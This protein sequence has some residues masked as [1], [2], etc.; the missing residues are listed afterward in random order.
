ME[1][2]NSQASNYLV[3]VAVEINKIEKKIA[4]NTD[5]ESLVE[6]Y[7]AIRDGSDLIK[8]KIREIEEKQLKKE[9]SGER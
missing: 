3:S 6:L 2:F 8:S 5:S 1:F 9:V 4:K 7:N